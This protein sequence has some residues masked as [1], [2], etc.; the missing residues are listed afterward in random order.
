[1]GLGAH[2]FS[3]FAAMPHMFR[4]TEFNNS[5]VMPSGRTFQTSL[6]V[7]REIEIIFFGSP[8]NVFSPLKI[9]GL[10]VV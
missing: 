3:G 1:M 10:R 9:N 8:E 4:E 6:L 5:S 7:S 2:T